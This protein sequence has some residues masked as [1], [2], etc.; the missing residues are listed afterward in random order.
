MVHLFFL[1]S[2]RAPYALLYDLG[3]L[4]VLYISLLGY[5]ALEQLLN[6]ASILKNSKIRIYIFTISYIYPGEV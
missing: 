3:L 4:L 2:M 5:P 1:K 6:L